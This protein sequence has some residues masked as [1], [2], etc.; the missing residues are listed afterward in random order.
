MWGAG[1]ATEFVMKSQDCFQDRNGLHC[2]VSPLS[3]SLSST[4]LPYPSFSLAFKPKAFSPLAAAKSRS[5]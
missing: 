3:L 2:R 4:P 5:A 1:D